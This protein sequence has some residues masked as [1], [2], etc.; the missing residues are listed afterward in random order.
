MGTIDAAIRSSSR[1]ILPLLAAAVVLT[2][3]ATVGVTPATAGP[4]VR[5]PAPTSAPVVIPSLS[6]WQPAP[7]TFEFGER[8]RI[9]LGPSAPA[10][11]RTARTLAE[12]LASRFRTTTPVVERSKPQKGDIVLGVDGHRDDL[13]AE[14][15][16]M[17]VSDIVY[18]TGA[19]DDGAF[20]G[21]RTLIQALAPNHQ[22]AAGRTVDVPRFP[23]RGVEICPCMVKLSMARMQRLFREM[24]FLKLN[25]MLLPLK[26]IST[27]HPETNQWSYYTRAEAEE[28]AAL[29]MKYH[30]EVI[31]EINAP[32]HMEPY[33]F[34][35]PDLQLTD[36]NG[37]HSP[38]RMDI[39]KPAAFDFYTDLIDEYVGVFPGRY[40]H[41]G[42]D[43]YMTFSSY[44][45][46]PQ[47]G[48]YARE[49]FGPDARPEDAFIDFI[50]RVDAH[51]RGTHGRTIRIW[52]DGL[53]RRNVIPAE[54]GSHPGLNTDIVIEHWLPSEVLPED[55]VAAGYTI[56]NAASSLYEDRGSRPSPHSLCPLD[57]TLHDCV[58]TLWNDGW[59]PTTF[60]DGSSIAAGPQL[61][62]AH[63]SLWQT[64]PAAETERQMEQ[65][66]ALAL[67]FIAE[68]TWGDATSFISYRDFVD[69]SQALGRAPGFADSLALPLASD[70]TYTVRSVGAGP[71]G[72]LTAENEEPDS[73]LRVGDAPAAWQLRRTDDGYYQVESPTSGLCMG[74]DLPG[75]IALLESDPGVGAEPNQ[76]PCDSRANAQK[77][78]ITR[79]GR[80]LYTITNALSQLVTRGEADGTVVQDVPNKPRASWDIQLEVAATLRVES[81]TRLLEPNQP[82]TVQLRLENHGSH[83]LHNVELNL[84]AP[85]HWRVRSAGGVSFDTVAAGTTVRTNFEV[86]PPDMSRGTGAASLL[87][88]AAYFAGDGGRRSVE[89]TERV[90]VD[91]VACAD[92][93]TQPVPAD[94]EF[95]GTQLDGCRWTRVI[96]PDLQT[97]SVGDGRLHI[98]TEPGDLVGGPPDGAKNVVL[99]RAPTGDWTIET[100]MQAH[101][102][103]SY[104]QGGLMVHDDD[105]NYVEFVLATENPPGATPNLYLS[106]VSEMDGEFRKGGAVN[107]FGP[108]GDSDEVCWLRLSK[109]GSAY[110][111]AFSTD[112][113]SWRPMPGNVTNPQLPD[114]YV[115]LVAVGPMQQ[116][117]TDVWFDYFRSHR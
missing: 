21:T 61:T 78:E 108:P 84:I 94:D 65:A 98:I 7:G 35:R 89:G 66:T 81:E 17:V 39:T 54:Q 57:A 102:M 99:Q 20:Y 77:W 67:R 100:K 73:H 112:G 5:P 64:D 51:V 26:M 44:D 24:A 50:N 95:D 115:G 19:T 18:I 9:V 91:P 101:L 103:E 105:D 114:P 4:A 104:Q 1:R 11:K 3:V 45:S 6:N 90:R 106:L 70:G 46:Y 2:T 23:E 30:V 49:K 13:G 12:D 116:A 47:I 31:P 88:G 92:P 111:A 86:I 40:W 27:S 25:Y 62:G 58:Q 52:N 93:D 29:G 59:G 56:M 60:E 107:L 32:G 38:A 41:L 33:L 80:S 76:Q 117:A 42:A 83:D 97:M 85:D 82:N 110:T 55:F 28:L 10:L 74:M 75:G 14:G 48:A 72:F 53:P 87:R 68:R 43:E 8:T 34:D 15:Y 16:E 71:R 109:T 22:I 113:E 36:R 63:L 69:R 96:N 79:N 37:N